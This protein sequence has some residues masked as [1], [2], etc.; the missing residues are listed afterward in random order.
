M[1][2]STIARLMLFCYGLNFTAVILAL[3]TRSWLMIA[4]NGFFVGYC[5]WWLEKNYFDVGEEDDKN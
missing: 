5:S 1:R 4:V 2:K 3:V